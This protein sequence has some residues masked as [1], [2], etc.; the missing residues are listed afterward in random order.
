MNA[1]S[2]SRGLPPSAASSQASLKL[3]RSWRHRSPPFVRYA[4]AVLFVGVA[5][6]VTYELRRS[7]NTPSFQTPFFVCAIALGSWLGGFGPGIVA[8]LL[9]IFA[10]EFVFTEPLYTF[11]FTWKE[12]PRF[13]VFFLTGF[14]ISWIARQQRRDEVAL[15]VAQESLE[16]KVNERTSDLRETNAKLTAEVAERARAEKE[17]RRLNRAARVRSYFNRSVARSADEGELVERV[18]RSMVDVGGHQAAKIVFARDGEIFIVAQVHEAALG[19]SFP[20]F[21]EKGAAGYRLAATAVREQVPRQ[22]RRSHDD[23][24]PDKWTHSQGTEAILALPLILDGQAIGSLLIYSEDPA[25]F[26]E[27]EVS[28]LQQA[29]ND[30]A[31]GLV[32]FRTRAARAAAEAA[33][34]QSQSE[35]A[36]VARLTT[37]G[38]LAASIAHEINQPLAAV[39]TNANACLRWLDR[40][41]PNL[42]EAREAARRIIRDGR[43]GSEVIARIRAL[44]K[45]E[46][47]VRS[48]LAVNEAIEEI[49]A[50]T[51]SELDGFALEIEL[52]DDLPLV[53]ADRVQ[54][55]QVVLN[56]ILNAADAMT[57][58]DG[59]AA[60]LRISTRLAANSHIEIA[61]RDAGI[62]LAPDRVGKVFDAFFSTKPNGLGMGLSICRSIVEHHGGHL[63]A[64]NNDGPG[65][66][67]RFT[68]PLEEARRQ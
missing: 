64:E 33:L 62:G 10:V 39:V 4:L 31:Q 24:N 23:T 50:L 28:L 46:D 22:Y 52:S 60:S 27:K 9:S 7:L 49:L 38:E 54:I 26:D 8:T 5:V 58:I 42:D 32:L 68:L 25:G 3:A 36:R 29:A 14:F 11:G 1:A 21:W 67:F 43:R 35:L 34:D 17:L 55:Q 40:E 44:L 30:V 63:R 6:F 47:S 12:V 19:E 15:L 18:C 41:T 13:L 57:G 56:L 48:P 45:K 53:P 59:R 37:M 16:E 61:V 51:R 66:T 2:H 20:F 65:A